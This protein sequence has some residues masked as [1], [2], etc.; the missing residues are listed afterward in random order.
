MSDEAEQGEISSGELPGGMFPEATR[1]EMVVFPFL[2]VPRRLGRV[3]ENGSPP[4]RNLE[5]MSIL[6]KGNHFTRICNQ[7]KK[8]CLSRLPSR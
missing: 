6:A 3:L 7:V 5:M 1:R 8:W 4:G 2:F